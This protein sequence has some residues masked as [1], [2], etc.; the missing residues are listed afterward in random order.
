MS[1]ALNSRS[2]FAWRVGTDGALFAGALSCDAAS[3]VVAIPA[4]IADAVAMNVRRLTFIR[5]P[6]EDKLQAELEN[7]W[8][9]R[10][11][12]VRVIR[13][14]VDWLLTAV[15]GMSRLII[16]EKEPWT[17]AADAHDLVAT[18]AVTP[19]IPARS[20]RRLCIKSRWPRRRN[21][22]RRRSCCR[23]TTRRWRQSTDERRRGRP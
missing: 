22:S 20:S 6:L 23:D 12:I 19:A 11:R 1:G 14:S 3:F 2:T 17:C 13:P 15:F 8:I 18:V 21:E 5:P 4:T 7:A 9:A 10:A 16:G